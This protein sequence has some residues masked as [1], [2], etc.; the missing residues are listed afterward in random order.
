MTV[1]SQRQKQKVIGE[2][3]MDGFAPT[4]DCIDYL[5]PTCDTISNTDLLDT[6]IYASSPN[7][8]YMYDQEKGDMQSSFGISPTPGSFAYSDDF[9]LNSQYEMSHDISASLLPSVQKN[10]A[11]VSSCKDTG[12]MWGEMGKMSKMEEALQFSLNPATS[13]PTLAELNQTDSFLD[14]L[15][16]ENYLSIDPMDSDFKGKSKDKTCSTTVSFLCDPHK[17][18]KEESPLDSMSDSNY[19]TGSSLQS[20]WQNELT[21]V[22]SAPNL[23][24]V[25][26]EALETVSSCHGPKS[27]TVL[28]PDSLSGNPMSNVTS[29]I[30]LETDT[31]SSMPKTKGDNQ[32]KLLKLLQKNSGFPQEES[33]NLKMP[34]VIAAV[35]AASVVGPNLR[36]KRTSGTAGLESMDEK[37]EEL[38]EIIFTKGDQSTEKQGGKPEYVRVKRER[39]DS[40]SSVMSYDESDSDHGDDDWHSDSDDDGCHDDDLSLEPGESLLGHD[41]KQYFWQYNLQSKGPK[42]QRVQFSLSSDPHILHDFEDPVFD[43]SVNNLSGIGVS[44]KHGGKAR[45]GDGNDIIPNPKKLFQIGLQLRKISR[46]INEFAPVS[47]LPSSARSM[48]KKE[49]NKLASRACRMKKKA[50][51]E[52]NKV[53]LYG[54]E[55]EQRQLLDVLCKIRLLLINKLGVKQEER[56][57]SEKLT[58]KLEKL[59]KEHLDE[60]IAGNTTEYVNSVIRRIEQGDST[61]GIL[62][63]PEINPH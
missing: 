56:G 44:I 60:R 27:C 59:I 57:V 53:K 28:A 54:L 13:E 62:H 35:P 61:G 17:L 51:H 16:V 23:Y 36:R 45:K 2:M 39:Y 42:G 7:S 21:S 25:K 26:R 55:Q 12:H 20:H 40:G 22:S 38:K 18:V 43:A 11:T 3:T 24:L 33:L 5:S 52:A 8:L 4:S 10:A 63:I 37:W 29:P 41:E 15:L 49:K 6:S 1:A 46:Q 58:E 32:S 48:T 47:V 9:D 34:K 31:L 30:K 50:Q 19:Y 14:D